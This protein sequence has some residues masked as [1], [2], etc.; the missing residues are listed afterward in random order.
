MDAGTN[1]FLVNVSQLADFSDVIPLSTT[2]SLPLASGVDGSNSLL[3]LSYDNGTQETV[4]SKVSV[5]GVV[6][7]ESRFYTGAESPIDNLVIRHANRE[8]TQFPFS[9]GQTATGAYYFNGFIDYTFSLVFTGLADD[10]DVDAI[11]NGQ[12]ENAGF[13]SVLPLSGQSYAASAYNFGFN[14]LLP[15]VSIVTTGNPP[16]TSVTDVQATGFSFPELESNARVKIIRGVLKGKN[17]VIFGSNTKSGQIGLYVYDEA[18]GEFLSSK[19][20]G[21]SNPFEVGALVQTAEGDLVVSGTT[22]V[23]GRLP[24]LCLIKVPKDEI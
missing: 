24:R 8:G 22:Y 6:S 23:A 19:Y 14:F 16:P 21:Y 10:E 17:V 15:N 20:L 5:A 13:S 18:T 12:Q 11:V 4:M 3:L 7:N 1:A 9:V 2:L